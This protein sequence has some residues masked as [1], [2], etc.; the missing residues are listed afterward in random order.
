MITKTPDYIISE[1]GICI[2]QWQPCEEISSP[3]H[4]YR[5][6]R[7]TNSS[8][9]LLP[10]RETLNDYYKS[11][12]EEQ[13]A[14]KSRGCRGKSKDDVVAQ[15]KQLKNQWNEQQKKQQQ[16]PQRSGSNNN[17]YRL[18]NT[19]KCNQVCW[20]NSNNNSAAA[21]TTTLVTCDLNSF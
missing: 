8:T 19:N 9:R 21:T 20:G 12:L 18:I 2:T 15:Q 1:L 6:C 3:C 13:R 16:Q 10:L 7:S 14:L 11:Q 17:N 5:N 4:Q